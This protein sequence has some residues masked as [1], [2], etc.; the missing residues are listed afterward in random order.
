MFPSKRNSTVWRSDSTFVEKLS[1]SRLMTAPFFVD[2]RSMLKSF[3]YF[4]TVVTPAK[5]S[6]ILPAEF[7]GYLSGEAFG[8][9]Y[10]QNTET[11]EL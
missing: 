11:A 6:K 2:L 7:T 9:Y 5:S 3:F 4:E 8:F 1:P 10:E